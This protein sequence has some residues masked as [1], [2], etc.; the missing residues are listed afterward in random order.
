MDNPATEEVLAH[1][2][3]GGAA[4][5]ARAVSA[6]K[7]A[8]E[9]WRWVSAN[10][11]AEMPHA[12]ARKTLLAVEKGEDFRQSWVGGAWTGRSKGDA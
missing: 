6:A 7:A 11:R 2:Q 1:V 10:E 5:V 4:D 3:R 12:V 9:H 8:F